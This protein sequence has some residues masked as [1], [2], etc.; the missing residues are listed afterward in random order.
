MMFDRF[1][2]P[3]LEKYIKILELMSDKKVIAISVNKENMTPQEV[4]SY[5]EDTQNKF[6]I[7]VFD[8]LGNLSDIAG[9]VKDTVNG[10]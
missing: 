9:Y 4:Q 10:P 5:I 7:P 3:P 8:P 6:G 1:R 2:I